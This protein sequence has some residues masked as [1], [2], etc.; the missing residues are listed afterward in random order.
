[1]LR[2]LSDISNVSFTF[3]ITYFANFVGGFWFWAHLLPLTMRLLQHQMLL[4]HGQTFQ[5]WS[6]I[7]HWIWENVAK[8][9][10]LRKI[11]NFIVNYSSLTISFGQFSMTSRWCASIWYQQAWIR[12]KIDVFEYYK[13]WSTKTLYWFFKWSKTLPHKFKYTE[14][15]LFFRPIF[16]I[17]F[18]NFEPLYAAI[19]N[20][21]HVNQ[22]YF[23]CYDKLS[24][25]R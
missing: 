24:K 19:G 11:C 6:K 7:C 4:F 1:M 12:I 8:G 5:L 3:N 23:L 9:V 16:F 14:I 20:D 2:F 17:F 18:C 10:E 25:H 22:Y 15:S 13:V 21:Y